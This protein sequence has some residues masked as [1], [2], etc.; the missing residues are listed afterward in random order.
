MNDYEKAYNHIN[1]Y[2]RTLEKIVSKDTNE[3]IND[4]KAKMFSLVK[5]TVPSPAKGMWLSA[6]GI[7]YGE[8]RNCGNRVNS[9]MKC[10]DRCMQMLDWS[11]YE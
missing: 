2:I 7:A 1:S 11:D 6:Q 9:T 5:K 10:C 4:C 8:C 3:L